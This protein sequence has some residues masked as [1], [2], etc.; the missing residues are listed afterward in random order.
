[1]VE[2]KG[3]SYTGLDIVDG[4]N[5]DILSTD[6][7]NYP[8]DDGSFDVV[9]SG[10]TM[11]HVQ[12][13]HRWTKELLRV[14]R[15]AGWVI[16]LTVNEWPEHKHPVDCWRILTDGMSFVLLN[17]YQASWVSASM[18]GRDTIGIARKRVDWMTIEG[19]ELLSNERRWLHDTAQFVSAR[20]GA[21]ARMATIGVWHGASMYCLRS[22]CPQGE[23]IG[24]DRDLSALWHGPELGTLALL[25]ADSR[26]CH[27]KVDGPLHLL[28]IDGDHHYDVIK[29]DIENWTPK[30]AYNG[31]VV[32]HDYNPT[33]GWVRQLPHLADVQRAVHEW[34]Q[35]NRG[36]WIPLPTVGSLA[37][38]RR[39]AE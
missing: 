17:T 21:E 23:M 11:E 8:L 37:A 31:T 39:I 14:V 26:V 12:D 35:A 15:P 34:L 32:F 22:G 36:Q 6:P 29:A 7:Y 19:S 10:S 2:T 25:E 13:L 4:G 16:I 27:E 18:D 1:M 20:F 5:V 24:V 9:I 28:L 30:V 3:W 33:P 38:F